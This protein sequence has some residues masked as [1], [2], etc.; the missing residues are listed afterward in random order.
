MAV[1]EVTDWFSPTA[2]NDE[3]LVFGMYPLGFVEEAARKAGPDFFL[4]QER[5]GSPRYSLSYFFGSARGSMLPFNVLDPTLLKWRGEM[6]MHPLQAYNT[7]W[8]PAAAT[9]TIEQSGSV[10]INRAAVLGESDAVSR[11]VFAPVRVM[12]S[13]QACLARLSMRP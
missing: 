13:Y 5:I 7:N 10:R 8:H 12:L 3:K 1:I 9:W 4:A 6:A 2:T 11:K